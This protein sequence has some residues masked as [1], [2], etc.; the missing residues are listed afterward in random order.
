MYLWLFHEQLDLLK[1]TIPVTNKADSTTDVAHEIL[2]LKRSKFKKRNRDSSF[3]AQTTKQTFKVL[4]VEL[5]A[6]LQPTN[7]LCKPQYN[8]N[9]L[10]KELIYLVVSRS[11]R[12]H[13]LQP[14]TEDRDVVLFRYN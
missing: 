9:E 3:T 12:G 14:K 10:L 4:E 5:I 13:L 1:N 11:V 8:T 6:T 2:N 7:L